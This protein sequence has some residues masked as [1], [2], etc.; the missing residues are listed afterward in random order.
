MRL[1]NVY[2][3]DLPG[4]SL[5]VTEWPGGSDPVLLLHATGF[6]SR[7][8]D[9]IARRLEDAHLYAVDLRFHGGSDRNGEVSW[10]LL[11][12]DIEQLLQK[13]DLRQV[14]GVGHSIGGYLVACVAARMRERFKHLVLID[15]VI[16]SRQRYI[17]QFEHPASV[18]TAWERVRKRKNKWRDAEE[19]YQRFHERPPF[20]RWHPQI[21][22]DYCEHALR[23]V[24]GEDDLQL[25]CDPLHETAIYLG[26]KGN[27][28]IHDLL[29]GLTLPVTL[30][31][32][33]PDPENPDN[34]AASPTWPGLAGALPDAREIYLP[35]MTHFIPMEDPELVAEVIRKLIQ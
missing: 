34:L 15:P 7:C 23:E 4:I 21:L 18:D 14:V 11:A 2:Q 13:L 26:Q 31:R 5:Q 24:P 10:Q 6:H 20:D 27:E 19:M 8:W 25:A 32:A 1:P 33:A 35:G 29:P 17:E 3:V 16:F 22:R 12:A 28:I 30:L 9:E